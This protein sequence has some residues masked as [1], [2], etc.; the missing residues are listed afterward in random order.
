MSIRK[1]P[2][3]Y[4]LV[5]P[6][7]STLTTNDLT[8]GG[9]RVLVEQIGLEQQRPQVS[10]KVDDGSKALSVTTIDRVMTWSMAQLAL[11]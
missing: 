4:G 8:K 11:Q 9:F 1:H 6:D 5:L 10:V 7:F 3:C 2:S